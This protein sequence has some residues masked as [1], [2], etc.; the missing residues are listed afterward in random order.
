M[1]IREQKNLFLPAWWI[2]FHHVMGN[3][4]IPKT[5]L[6]MLRIAIFSLKKFVWDRLG[7]LC[8]VMYI[9]N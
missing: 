4:T 9:S 3:K 2:L 8:D 1:T 5:G 7:F 6:I